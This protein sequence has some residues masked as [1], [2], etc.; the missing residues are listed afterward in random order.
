MSPDARCPR[1]AA[2]VAAEAP[3]CTLCFTSLRPA[4]PTPPPSPSLPAPSLPSP[5]LP[6]PDTEPA[7]GDTLVAAPPRGRHRAPDPAD[8]AAPVGS[9]P[10][11]VDEPDA[12]GLR[13]PRRAAGATTWP[14][15]RCQAEVALELHACPDCGSAFLAGSGADGLDLGLPYGADLLAMSRGRRLALAGGAALVLTV[16]L[17]GLMSLFSLLG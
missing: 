1:C 11:D 5:S 9:D 17:T 13:L 3:W 10:L 4:A 14:C 8:L 16:L 6:A 7:A 12:A 15:A 2:L